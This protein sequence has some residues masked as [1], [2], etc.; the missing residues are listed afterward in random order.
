M[1]GLLKCEGLQKTDWLSFLSESEDFHYCHSEE[2]SD[3]ESQNLNYRQTR[4]FTQCDNSYGR[5]HIVDDKYRVVGNRRPLQCH[6]KRNRK[7]PI[8]IF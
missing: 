7:N 5:L 2:R 6:S 4:P 1:E 3:E 8:T